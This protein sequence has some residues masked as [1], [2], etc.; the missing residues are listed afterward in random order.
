[1]VRLQDMRYIVTRVDKKTKLKCLYIYDE[2]IRYKK[3]VF[4]AKSILDIYI[5]KDERV[6]V[7]TNEDI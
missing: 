5:M 1:V 3:E 7:T 2:D 6:V 4:K